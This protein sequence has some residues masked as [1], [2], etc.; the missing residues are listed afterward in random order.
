[1]SVIKKAVSVAIC[2]RG[3]VAKGAKR[4]RESLEELVFLE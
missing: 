1:M 3:E 2:R 4:S